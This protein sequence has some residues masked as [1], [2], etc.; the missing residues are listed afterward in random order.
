MNEQRKLTKILKLNKFTAVNQTIR[1]G[2]VAYNRVAYQPE[3][4]MFN[5][6]PYIKWPDSI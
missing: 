6:N 3:P 1:L 2:I 5:C 4:L